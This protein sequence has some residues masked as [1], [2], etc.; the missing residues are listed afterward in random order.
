MFSVNFRMSVWLFSLAKY[1]ENANLNKAM[2]ESQYLR[3]IFF[4]KPKISKP[5]HLNL[6][7]TV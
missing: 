5:H 4:M 2:N 6:Y 3:R 7:Y 1:A